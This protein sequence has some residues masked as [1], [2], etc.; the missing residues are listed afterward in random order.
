MIIFY[1][2]KVLIT[3]IGMQLKKNSHGKCKKVQIMGINETF[4]LLMSPV[5]RV[6][7]HHKEKWAIYMNKHFTK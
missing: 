5:N 1:K 4:V 2:G 3:S 7:F 6:R